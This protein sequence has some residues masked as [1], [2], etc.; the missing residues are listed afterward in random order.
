M[1]KIFRES[2]N[3][4]FLSFLRV[5]SNV[6]GINP[7]ITTVWMVLKPNENNGISTTNYQLSTNLNWWV[8]RISEP[9]TVF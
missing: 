1:D 8:Y 9:S 3:V 4:C 7:A 5:Y 6:D 2:D